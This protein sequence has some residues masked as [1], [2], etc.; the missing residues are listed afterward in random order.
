MQGSSHWNETQFDLYAEVMDTFHVYDN[1][2]GF[3]IGNERIVKQEDSLTVPYYKAATRDMKA[4]RDAKGYRKIPIGYSAAHIVQLQPMLQNYLTCG[5]NSSEIVDFYG[6]NSYSW[7]KEQDNM[8]TSAYDRLQSY[9][10]D[11]PVPIF[12][13]E[14]GCQTNPPRLFGDQDAIFSD[15]MVGTWSG[16]IIYEWIQEKNDYG[17]ISYGPPAASG[18]P[19]EENVADGFTRKGTPTPIS[20]DFSNL[21]TKWASITPTGVSKKDYDPNTVVTP[22]CPSSTEGG[23][24]QVDGNVKLPVLGEEVVGTYSKIPSATADPSDTGKSN[25]GNGG[26]DGDDADDADDDS[27]ASSDKQITLVGSVIAAT[28]LTIALVL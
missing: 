18:A 6:V 20:P 24:W 13:S 23:W 7:C 14:T 21:K 19:N 25:S 27:A 2:L 11:F 16:S 9:A 10:E 26:Q 5:G 12:F 15:P 22:E 8:V 28:V 3:F 4:Y 1:V 17:L